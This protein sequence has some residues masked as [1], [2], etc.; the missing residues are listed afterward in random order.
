MRTWLFA[1][2]LLGLLSSQL[3]AQDNTELLNRMKAMEDRI[4]TLEAEVQSLKEIG[5]AHV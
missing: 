4:K 2:V 1:P 5:R 3:P